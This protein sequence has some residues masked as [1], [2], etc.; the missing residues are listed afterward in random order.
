MPSARSDW[1]ILAPPSQ[2]SAV[3]PN[4]LRIRGN[5]DNLIF[6]FPSFVPSIK[7]IPNFLALSTA[8]LLFKPTDVV[9]TLVFEENSSE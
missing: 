4:S 8:C 3:I 5:S 9:I 1:A 2:Y 7:A 6:S